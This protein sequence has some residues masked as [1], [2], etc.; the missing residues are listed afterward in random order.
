MTD[1]RYILKEMRAY[2][3]YVCVFVVMID[4]RSVGSASGRFGG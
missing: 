2:V 1:C 3:W 4:Y